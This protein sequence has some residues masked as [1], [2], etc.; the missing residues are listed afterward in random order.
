[1]RYC[2]PE[3][4]QFEKITLPPEFS[5]CPFCSGKLWICGHRKRKLFSLQGPKQIVSQITHCSKE[6]CPG[7]KKTFNPTSEQAIAMPR[8]LIGWDV[9]AFIGHRRFTYNHSVNEI[10]T[11]LL[12]NYQIVISHDIIENH[13]QFYQ[14]IVAAR[15][16]DIVL[17]TQKYSSEKDLWLSI[18][19]I[20]PEK[21]HETLY[22]VREIRQKRVLFAQPLLSST[23]DELEKLF[24]RAKEMSEQLK[25][26]VGL[27]MSDKQDA[28]VKGI[29]K[30]FPSVPH[31]YCENHFLRDV[32]K[33]VLEI[34]S[35][36]KVDLRKKIRGLSEVEREMNKVIAEKIIKNSYIPGKGREQ[37]VLDYCSGLRG[38]I[39]DDQGG[40]LYPPGLKMAEATMEF[41]DSLVECLKMR[42]GGE[43]EKGI[44]KLVDLIENAL[45]SVKRRI[46][47]IRK[48]VS[49]IREVNK[50][51][52][53]KTGTQEDRKAKLQ[54]LYTQ[55][56]STIDKTLL[57]MAG[58]MERFSPGL[59]VG[60]DDPSLPR[61]NLELERF[62]RTPKGH[63]RRIHGHRHAGVR[64][65]VEGATLIPALDA[66]LH[67]PEGFKIVDLLPYKNVKIPEEQKKS[68][69][70]KKK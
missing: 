34:D 58:V 36:M 39:T 52:D 12:N 54:N 21:G 40:P 44:S 60:G 33:Q 50:C 14:S 61:D 24:I 19:G 65:V 48:Y 63:E 17:L 64:I 66:H 30:I 6:D 53:P 47:T 56:N 27:W 13:I 7:S 57:Y 62:F 41:R 23:S 26:P 70:R 51:I 37:V 38:I 46:K 9:V 55:Y 68:K 25:R 15:H 4:T 45:K 31:R 49:E 67:H 43:A 29:S 20:Q 8:W 3:D 69:E 22:V 5:E 18:D 1:M 16:T 35:K 11:E 59:F 2:W 42:K 28:F 10:R 32:A